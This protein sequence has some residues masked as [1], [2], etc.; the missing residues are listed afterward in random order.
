MICEENLSI[1][2]WKQYLS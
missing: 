1:I 2:H